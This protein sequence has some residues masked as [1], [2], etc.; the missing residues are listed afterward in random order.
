MTNYFAA[1][2]FEVFTIEGLDDRMKAIREHIQPVFQYIGDTYTDY[3]ND[4]TG[5]KGSFHIAQHRRRTTNPA[6][7]TWSAIGGDNRGYKKYPHIQIGINEEHIFMFLS[8]IDNPKHEKAM[9][10]SLLNRPALW[11]DLPDDYF[12][13]GDHTKSA[14]QKAEVEIIGNTLNRLLNVKKGEFMIGRI[15]TPASEE[16]SDNTLQ[17]EFF[18]NTLDGLLPMYKALLDLYQK[19]ENK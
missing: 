10:E 5:F 7:S 16:L 13:S 2:D 3:V 15:L 17:M 12:I 14:I 18:K 6:E 1:T 4:Y 8:L 11:S 9:G 19:E